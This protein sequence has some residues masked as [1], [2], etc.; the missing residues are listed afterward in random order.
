MPYENATRELRF[1]IRVCVTRKRIN[2]SRMKL[3]DLEITW[4]RQENERDKETYTICTYTRIFLREMECQMLKHILYF[5]ELQ[6]SSY[7]E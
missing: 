5:C 7:T 2:V 6:L 4:N 3:L 1:D